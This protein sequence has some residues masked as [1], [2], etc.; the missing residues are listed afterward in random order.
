R[1]D[2]PRFDNSAVDGYGVRADDGRMP[3][4]V[5]REVGAGDEP[6]PAIGPGE[7]VRIFTGA[8]VPPGVDAVAMQ[9]DCRADGRS[10]ELNEAL[11]PGANLRRRGE[12]YR[13]GDVLLPAGT[14]INPAVLSLLAAN[15][16]SSFRFRRPPHVVIVS[17]GEELGE[18]GGEVAPWGVY[19]SN[20]PGLAAAIL[21]LGSWFGQPMTYQVGDRAE[22]TKETLR[23]AL[24]EADILITTGGVSVGDRDLVKDALEELG[25]ER[26]FWR[27]SMKPGKPVF[28]GVRDKKLVFGLPGNPVSAL[29]AFHLLVRPA[30]RRMM[31]HEQALET[32]PARLKSA[33]DKREGRAEFVRGRI[34]GGGD[35]L[36]VA[37]TG[38]QASYMM[39]GTAEADCLIHLPTGPGR[40]EAG[41]IVRV[42]LLRWGLI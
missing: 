14:P 33:I 19:N 22:A 20:G 1:L 38:R 34:D 15:G 25:V 11:R 16:V 37:P 12:E 5:V 23:T 8:A 18:L 40:F 10:V 2:S 9:E 17:T 27:I 35:V 26:V 30:F 24:H 42:S 4:R 31:G 28:F 36:E 41:E 3:R 7:A 39:L 6:G 32:W 21:S 13:E 29:M